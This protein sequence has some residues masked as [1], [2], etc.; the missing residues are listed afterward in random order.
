MLGVKVPKRG[1]LSV[2]PEDFSPPQNYADSVTSKQA[3]TL[4]RKHAKN[5][6][7]VRNAFEALGVEGDMHAH[8]KHDQQLIAAHKAAY[9]DLL[10]HRRCERLEAAQLVSGQKAEVD[11]GMKPFRMLRKDGPKLPVAP[12]PLWLQDASA[13][14]RCTPFKGFSPE[15]IACMTPHKV[16]PTNPRS[17]QHCTI[18]MR[19]QK[20]RSSSVV[21]LRRIWHSLRMK[22]V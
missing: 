5:Q 14:A 19:I 1:G 8:A 20:Y 7:L 2:L 12:E 17:S 13:P 16:W 4:K 11:L 22:F 15:K 10:R 9:K 3:W 6:A 21:T 18:S